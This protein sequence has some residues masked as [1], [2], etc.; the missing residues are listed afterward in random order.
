MYEKVHCTA[1]WTWKKIVLSCYIRTDIR[2]ELSIDYDKLWWIGNDEIR[3]VMLKL[4]TKDIGF[5]FGFFIKQFNTFQYRCSFRIH[6]IWTWLITFALFRFKGNIF[7]LSWTSPSNYL[8]L[9]CL[10]ELTLLKESQMQV[11]PVFRTLRYSDNK[12]NILP[13]W[14]I[15]NIKIKKL[16]KI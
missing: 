3:V 15:K 16:Q 14:K 10:S 4:E 11:L 5:N 9:L 7:C 8:I 12:I 1:D 6:H 13:T 2:T